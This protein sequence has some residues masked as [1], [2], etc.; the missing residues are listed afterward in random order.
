M[1]HRLWSMYSAV[2]VVIEPFSRPL[3]RTFFVTTARVVIRCLPALTQVIDFELDRALITLATSPEAHIAVERMALSTTVAFSNLESVMG[4]EGNG[5]RDTRRHQRFLSMAHFQTRFTGSAKRIWQRAWG[6]TRGTA[7]FILNVGRICAFADEKKWT[8]MDHSR[9]PQADTSHSVAPRFDFVMHPSHYSALCLDLPGPTVC[10]LSFEFGPR[11]GIIE[12]RGISTSLKLPAIHFSVESLLVFLR[13]TTELKR[14]A[15]IR[16]SD[17][18]PLHRFK[19]TRADHRSEAMLKLSLFR[20]AEIFIKD[21]TVKFSPRKSGISK[22]FIGHTR[23]FCVSLQI[24]EPVMDALRTDFLGNYAK[25]DPELDADVMSISLSIKE[26]TVHRRDLA[27]NSLPSRVVFVGPIDLQGFATQWAPL[28]LPPARIFPGDPNASLVVIKL[29]IDSPQLSE[30]V[31]VIDEILGTI[32]QPETARSDPK[33]CR[34]DTH[35]VP[36]LQVDMNIRD[37]AACL[38]PAESD[39]ELASIILSS[40]QSLISLSTSFKNLVAEPRLP[41]FGQINCVPLDMDFSTQSI[42]GPAFVTVLPKPLSLDTLS[43]EKPYGRDASHLGDPFLSLSAVELAVSGQICGGLLEDTAEVVLDM[44]SVMTEVKCSADAIS[45][46]LWQPSVLSSTKSLL[47]SIHGSQKEKRADDASGRFIDKFP[48]GLFVHVAVGQIGLIVTGKDL[49]PNEDLDLSRGIAMKTGLAIQYCSLPNSGHSSR[50]P[51]WFTIAHDRQRLYLPEELTTEAISISKASKRLADFALLRCIALD[52]TLRTCIAT[53][54]AADHAYDAEEEADELKSAEFFWIKRLE[55]NVYINSHNTDGAGRERLQLSC[56]IPYV[57]L[58]FQLFEA[59]C[60]FLALSTLQLLSK[61]SKSNRKAERK[62]STTR[63]ILSCRASINTVQLLLKLPLQEQIC[64]RINGLSIRG[65]NDSALGIDWGVVLVWV[66]ARREDEKWEEL[67]RLRSWKVSLTGSDTE[68][69][70]FAVDSEGARLRVPFGYVLADLILDFNV[71]FKCLRHLHDIVSCKEFKPMPSPLPEEAK[72]VPV[73]NIKIG[74]LSVEAADDPSESKLGLIWRAGF[75]ATRARLERDEAFEAKVDAISAAEA[76]ESDLFSAGQRFT[77]QHSVSVEEARERLS[78][79]H[80]ISWMSLHREFRDEQSR[81]EDAIRRRIRGDHSH[82]S[83]VDIEPLVPLAPSSKSPPLLRIILTEVSLSVTQPLF[84][85]CDLQD[86]LYDLGNGLPRNSRFTLLLPL[87]LNVGLGSSCVTLRDYPLPLLNI[88]PE[89]SKNAVAWV[90]DTDL[91]IAEEFGTASSIIRKDCPVISPGSGGNTGTKPMAISVPKTTMPVKTYANPTIN[92]LT[93]QLT[94]FCWGVSYNAALQDVMRIID[95]LSTPPPDPSPTVG[96]WDKVRLILHCRAEVTF[97]KEVHLNLK[98]SRDPYAT[99]GNGAG[100]AFCW[101]GNTK[102]S[103]GHQ[104]PENEFLQV[105]SDTMLIVIPEF[106]KRGGGRDADADGMSHSA[107]G[108]NPG[109]RGRRKCFRRTCAK[110]SSGIRWGIGFVLERTCGTSCLKCGGSFACRL[111]NFRPHYE[112]MLE[113]KT[114]IPQEKTPEDSFNEFR[115]DFIHFST[116]L[117]SPVRLQASTSGMSSNTIHLTP[118]TFAHFWSWWELFDRYLS[119]P[120]RQ[121]VLFPIARLPSK[122]FGRHLATLKYRLTIAQLFISHVYMDDSKEAWAEGIT[123]FVGIKALVSLFEADLHQREQEAVIPGDA[124]NTNK[125]V[126]H[127]PF[128]AAE[129]KLVGLQLRAILATFVDPLKRLVDMEDPQK[130]GGLRDV[131]VEDGGELTSYWVDMDDFAETDWE[132]TESKPSLHMLP[133]GACPRF[134]YFKRSSGHQHRM[135]VGSSHQVDPESSRFGSEETHVCLMGKEPSVH[136]TQSEIVA[137]RISELKKQLSSIRSH[138][139]V[140][141]IGNGQSYGKFH[142]PKFSLNNS[143]RA[144][145]T[146]YYYCSRSRR[147]FEY[148]MAT[149]A[150]M[151]IRDQANAYAQVSVNTDERDR[152]FKNPTGVAAQAAAQALKK[153]LI[154]NEDEDIKNARNSDLISSDDE[155]FNPMDGWSEGVSLNKSHFCLLLKPQVLL[156]DSSKDSVLVLAAV[157]ATLQSFAI[158]DTANIEDPI[159]GRVMTRSHAVL[160]GLQTFSPSA[161]CPTRHDG[162]PLEVLIDLRAESKNFDRLVPQTHAT[163]RYDKFN[164]LRLRNKV[165]SVLANSTDQMNEHLQHQTDLIDVKVPQF[166]VFA[167]S[168]NFEAIAN[169]ITNVL[170]QSESAHKMHLNKVETLL[171]SYDFTDL[172]SA[173]D[174]VEGLQ[175]RLRRTV[176]REKHLESTVEHGDEQ[177]RLDLMKSKARIFLLS[178]E[179]NLIFDAIKLSQ[180]KADDKHSDSKSALKVHAWSKE[181]SWGMVGDLRDMIAKLAVRGI[182]FTWLSRQDGSTV[183][184][185]SM[186]D[187]QAFDGSPDAEW[188]EIL[189]KHREPSNHSLVKRG[190]FVQADWTVLA[191][192]G[193]ITIYEQFVIEL[194]PM[195]LQ[196]EA[197]VGKSIMEYVWPARRDRDRRVSENESATSNTLGEIA[198]SDNLLH[199]SENSASNPKIMNRASLDA[200]SKLTRKKR[201]S[202]EERRPT[203]TSRRITSS[204]SFTDLRHA[205]HQTS[206]DTT[207]TSSDFLSVDGTSLAL[208]SSVATMVEGRATDANQ[209]DLPVRKKLDDAAEM[210]TRSAQKHFV[211]VRISSMH[212]L[213]SFHK[214]GSFFCRDARIQTRELQYRNRTWS[215]EEL[216]EQFIPSDTSWRGWMRVALHQPLVPVFPVARELLS[217]TKWIAAKGKVARQARKFSPAIKSAQVELHLTADTSRGSEQS[218]HESQN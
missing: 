210:K 186:G 58:R 72:V 24:G 141:A 20:T 50:L 84:D 76:E 120:I 188:P 5:S 167:S 38:I 177:G 80:A 203:L 198:G 17:T 122:K 45:I 63:L 217:K 127:K 69:S 215:F 126:R 92:V 86:F 117:A 131:K 206:R 138:P 158:L 150:V 52:T 57:R 88:P 190:L 197:R 171:F 71:F 21:I 59:Y 165:T 139:C 54:F 123:R 95:T 56:R 110:F 145:L 169:I 43:G 94:E 129:V 3:I 135:H 65:S 22:L 29:D 28:M 12:E 130:E 48:R 79:V 159:S 67:A 147:G 148:H 100:F 118:K 128:Y 199:G 121:G 137:E 15:D 64:F 209:M 181:I 60:I 31:D 152:R 161:T 184:K 154:G 7:S 78:Q 102:M 97:V 77:P 81:K 153:I 98:G 87:H 62:R 168:K 51:G 144:I 182:D 18:S 108:M 205:S 39:G 101:D 174:V 134:T 61:S 143:T 113:P 212:I 193:G 157:Q 41:H 37:I 140:S 90:I 1:A 66:P 149:R 46:E 133:L 180:D 116:S 106:E 103:I 156:S 146:Q 112:I 14:N 194:H 68:P 179:L 73:I 47:K 216:A 42:L 55:A 166:T 44:T 214:D 109:L 23:N 36:R 172:S 111:F 136:Q 218:G 189:T 201:Y 93:T 176:E 40:T 85:A 32:H 187:L 151:F 160:S 91:V 49:N 207:P 82:F 178:E 192:V 163:F 191:P 10:M 30:R 9:S 183:N 13:A 75:D 115:S 4:L 175:S 170:L 142:C 11:K 8:F 164:R 173:A 104:N 35:F 34:F 99:D 16:N 26:V 2:Y 74:C 155:N 33:A 211:L 107:F 27:E 132:P 25:R 208:D 96:F 124:P 105:I 83:G 70:I 162:V 185:L 125:K 195:R 53:E 202:I 213:L 200:P 196:L 204:R 19:S 6:R 114:M 89:S 119:I